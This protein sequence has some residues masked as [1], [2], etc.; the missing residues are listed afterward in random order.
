MIQFLD[1]L[2]MIN[3]KLSKWNCRFMWNY[4]KRKI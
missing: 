3:M 2:F 1:M 4:S